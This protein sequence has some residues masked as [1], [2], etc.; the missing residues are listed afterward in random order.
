MLNVALYGR[1]VRR[2]TMTE[3]GRSRVQRDAGRFEV[4]P[5]AVR[6]ERDRLEIDIVERV[7]SMH[8]TLDVPRF[9]STAVRLMLPWRMPRVA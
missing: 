3:R 7:V 5:S 8:E 4:R 1:G 9:E 2:W 6:W